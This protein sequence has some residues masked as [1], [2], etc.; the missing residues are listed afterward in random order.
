MTEGQRCW[1][2][3]RGLPGKKCHGVSTPVFI[4]L[5]LLLSCPSLKT[6]ACQQLLWPLP[7]LLVA[8]RAKGMIHV[9]DFSTSQ[10]GGVEHSSDQ[11]FWNLY[12]RATNLCNT[13]SPPMRPSL[14]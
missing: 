11:C 1:V 9:M 4:S 13:S 12:T 7:S 10:G 14:P 2:Q 6:Q 8:F 5:L 3:L